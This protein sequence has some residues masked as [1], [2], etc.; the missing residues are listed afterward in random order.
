METKQ[1][2]EQEF[3]DAAFNQGV[4]RQVSRFY[5][6]MDSCHGFY[7]SHLRT[8]CPGSRVLEIGCGQD[9]NAFFMGKLGAAEVCGIDISN[10]A[11]A[12]AEQRAAREQIGG[13]KFSVMDAENLKFGDDSFDLICGVAI[14]HHLDLDKA[15]FHIS[16]TLRPGGTAI[17]LEPLAH[18]PIVNLYRRLTPSLRTE[19]EHPL[20]MRDLENARKYFGKIDTTAFHLFSL[21]MAPF[22]GMPGFDR[23]V[24]LFDTS[25]QLLFK[26]APYLR[27]FAWTMGIVFSEPKVRKAAQSA[28][29]N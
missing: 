14:L 7:R 26:I 25:D 1:R 2:K 17:F 18:N 6:I 8:H 16:R 20:L 9:S 19:D 15:L 27:R 23:L 22:A 21:A 24:H 28:S 29:S 5:L 4:R 11:I 12:Q 13:L 3:H 10:V